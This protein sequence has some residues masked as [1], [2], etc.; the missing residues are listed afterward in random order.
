MTTTVPCVLGCR[1]PATGTPY[2]AAPGALA[3][4]PCA[5]R[6]A[7]QLRDLVDA[8]ALTDDPEA[9]LPART[10]VPGAPGYGPRSP[11]ND[12]LLGQRDV[13]SRWT[14]GTG[15][16]AL[17]TVESWARLVR[18]E[19]GAPAPDGRVTLL[20]EIATIRH[21]WPRV[22]ASAWLDEF[23]DEIRGALES[24]ARA[25]RMTEPTLR[26]GP[27]PRPADGGTCGTTL[28]VRAETDEI[29]C[30]GCGHT[31]PRSRW[32]ELGDDHRD[33]PTL[34][35]ELGVPIGTLRRWA[36]EDEWTTAG[37][38]RRRLWLRTQVIASYDRRRGGHRTNRE[39]E[40]S[41]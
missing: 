28:R 27:C 10:G 35:A 32:A 31:W 14:S 17:A 1:H 37:T 24:L 9:L 29:R 15:Y 26:V 11:A 40:G 8:Y 3:C 12:H 34:S 4:H 2:P 20:R 5:D 7:A 38:P 30:R 16:P 13:R 23:A 39:G 25:G 18:E 19:A 22:L 21:H 33:Y 6:L 36:T 41:A